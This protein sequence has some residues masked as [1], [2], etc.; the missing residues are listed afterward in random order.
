MR[1]LLTVAAV[2]AAACGGPE[3]SRVASP[4]VAET[5]GPRALLQQAEREAQAAEAACGEGRGDCPDYTPSIDTLTRLLRAQP[6]TDEATAALE[7]L[8]YFLERMGRTDEARVV[9]LAA[10]CPEHVPDP[11][12][13]PA[14]PVHEQLARCEPRPMSSRR[15]FLVWL[16]LGSLFFDEPDLERAHAALTRAV[17]IAPDD[18]R[19]ADPARYRLA[20]TLYRMDR[21]AEAL[22]AFAPL[23]GAET[24]ELRTEALQYMAII[25]SEPD[26][27]GDGADDP[28]HGARRPE[29]EE[30]LGGSWAHAPALALELARVLVDEARY[31]DAVHVCELFLAR[32]PDDARADEARALRNRARGLL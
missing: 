9:W 14:L 22:E 8:G 25:L 27:D 20:W 28:V 6:G 12:A 4:R 11:L 3:A 18:P 16:R 31:A 7:P 17:A 21:F 1:L 5:A 2:L 24:A 29:A 10:V 26:W 13:S 30:W 23:A 32:W 15:T 19:Y